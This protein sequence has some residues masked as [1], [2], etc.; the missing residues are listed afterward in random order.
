MSAADQAYHRLRGEILDGRLA[1]GERL[2]AAD[3]LERFQLGLTPIR[4]ALMRLTAENLVE[5]S[6][7]RGARVAAASA[8]GFADLMATRRVIERQ[9][10]T[11]AIT[12]GDA[13]WE[14][15][16][17]ASMHVLQKTALPD[18]P[19]GRLAWEARHRRFHASLVAACGSP[20]LLHFWHLLADHS[21]RYR[22]IR[23]HH[24]R[25][26]QAAVRDVAGEH[27]DLMDAVLARDIQRATT[28]MDAHL[29][30][31]EQSVA[32]LLSA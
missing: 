4:E 10:L 20:W 12:H 15:E 16:I 28:L 30:R 19:E 22:M 8:S 21:Q 31:T 32:A 26:P 9:C 25:E 7:H 2:A 11:L 13:D 5:T 14:A 24:H 27:R 23:L 17:V 6:T 18:T 1:P 29:V 3:L